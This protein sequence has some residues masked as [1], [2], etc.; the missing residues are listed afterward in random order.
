MEFT[1][2]LCFQCYLSIF[3]LS[4]YHSWHSNG[5]RLSRWR[6]T[7]QSLLKP[8]PRLHPRHSRLSP[9]LNFPLFI[10]QSELEILEYQRLAFNIIITFCIR[11]Q[12][13]WKNEDKGTIRA[14]ARNQTIV[15]LK[16]NYQEW[17]HWVSICE[18]FY[19]A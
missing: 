19:L 5:L 15:K 17:D 14:Y 3:R 4:I 9:R 18:S 12:S 16:A 11:S 1:F 6:W 8:P 10:L 13:K 2:A 7:N